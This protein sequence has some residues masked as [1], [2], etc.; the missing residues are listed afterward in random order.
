M[1]EMLKLMSDII[2]RELFGLSH[3]DFIAKAKQVAGSEWGFINWDN[4]D[5]KA[6]DWLT[7]EARAALSSVE[8]EIADRL[9]S[10]EI[11]AP[12]TMIAIIR[13]TAKSHGKVTNIWQG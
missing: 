12:E 8:G 2:Y 9:N 6:R 11:V 10:I 3:A 1:E 4:E 5:E 13:H 7:V